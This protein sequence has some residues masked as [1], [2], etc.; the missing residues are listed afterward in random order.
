M[1]LPVNIMALKARASQDGMGRDTHCD[2]D[3]IPGGREHVRVIV[4]LV[5][6]G[7]LPGEELTGELGDRGEGAESSQPSLPGHPK[8]FILD[9]HPFPRFGALLCH[10]KPLLWMSAYACLS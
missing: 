8:L 4:A 10:H 3:R 7:E 2:H 1:D 6:L 9:R 5:V